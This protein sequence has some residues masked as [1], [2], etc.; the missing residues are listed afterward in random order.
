MLCPHGQVDSPTKR[1]KSEDNRQLIL[2]N[3]KDP[4][5]NLIHQYKEQRQILLQVQH[6]RRFPELTKRQKLHHVIQTITIKDSPS[7][8]L[9]Q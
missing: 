8:E 4:K 9:E 3:V 5:T 1:I 6:R 2:L 7:I